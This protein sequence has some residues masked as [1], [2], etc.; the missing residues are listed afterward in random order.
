MAEHLD[1]DG[2]THISVGSIDTSAPQYKIAAKNPRRAER[3]VGGSF[4]VATAGFAGFGA[5]F[6]QNASNEWLGLTLTLG[7]VGLG[8]GMVLWGKFLM[9]QG[10]FSEERHAMAPTAEEREAFV[11]A[12]S[13]RGRVAIERRTFL[14]KLLGLAAGVFGVVAA[15]PLLRSLGP[16]PGHSLYTTAWK[17]DSLLVD[18]TGRPIKVD[19]VEVGGY[20]TVFPETDVGGAYS[21]TM[22]VRPGPAG[23]FV[24]PPPR[25]ASTRANWG[26]EGYLAFS[27]VC[28]HAG[29]PVG[30]Y[31]ELTQQMLCPC[32]Q[33]LFDVLDAAQPVFGPAP[34]PLPQLPLYVDPKGY[35]RAQAPY[36]EPV[37]PGFWERGSG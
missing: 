36:D 32:H 19:D 16:L 34:R 13:S 24:T 9:P 4:L 21:Q 8:Y 18:F 33:S 14:G 27:K 11:G 28:T 22:L 29:C 23:E 31:Q 7:F 12:F 26:P 5:A 30:L 10:P 6:W 25:F 1:G 17:K 2:R 15:F 20:I 3:V 37:G 35:L